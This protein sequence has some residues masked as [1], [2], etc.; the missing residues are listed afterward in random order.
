MP[1]ALTFF[2]FFAGGGMARLGLGDAWRCS[3]ANEWSPKKARSYQENFSADELVVEDVAKLSIADLP[4]AP[5]LCWGSFPCQ[6]LSL[7]GA[8]RGLAGERSGT[9]DSF[10]NLMLDLATDGRKPPLVVLENV[11][12]AITSNGG[13]DFQQL[14][15]EIAGA[16][17]RFG[18]LV[19]DAAKF[20]PQSRPRLFIVAFDQALPLPPDIEAP[21]DSPSAWRTPALWQAY[22]KSNGTENWIWWRLPDPPPCKTTLLQLLESNSWDPP[23]KTHSLLEMMSSSNR[24]KV[25]KAQRSRERVAG[26]IYRRTRIVNGTRV[27]RAEV[28]FD[29]LSGCL[30]TPAGGS[31]R[32]TIIEVRGDRVR[33]RLLSA[34]EAARLMGLPDR[35]RLPSRYNEAYHLAG[36]GVVLPVVSWLE[37][38]LLRP[39]AAQAQVNRTN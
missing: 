11:T 4:G 14:A 2:E 13:A 22:Q 20:V 39:L 9:F 5:D 29:D 35:Y 27:Q 3:F 38:H 32:Q 18:P 21:F 31:S 28:R 1:A 25:A 24:E 15:T 16:G 36:D 23:E 10:W 33:T 19:I 34:R 7:A 26:A 37:Q 8:Q 17:Y 12:G 6:D 30:R